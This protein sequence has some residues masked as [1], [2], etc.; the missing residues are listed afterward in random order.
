M[1]LKFISKWKYKNGKKGIVFGWFNAGKKKI[2]INKI[3]G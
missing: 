1:M 3:W 2:K